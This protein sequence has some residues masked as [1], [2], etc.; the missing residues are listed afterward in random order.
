MNAEKK[1]IDQVLANEEIR[2]LI[3]ALGSGIGEDF[4]VDNLNYHKV[5]I[6]S[7]ADVDGYHIRAIL[8]TFFFRYMKELITEGHVFIGLPP[9]YK[10]EKGNQVEYC[11]DDAAL[12]EAKAKMGK[13]ALVQRYKG[14]GE[15][16][17]DQLW[18]TTMNPKQ[19]SLM[20]VS[21]E[22][23]AEAEKLVSVLMGDAADLRREYIIEHADFNKVDTFN[24]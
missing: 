8:L 18:E 19:R 1:R 11:Y 7:D 12:A 22:D 21:I 20:Q 4:N 10:V 2:T 24:K 5:I 6:L 13:G 3:S 17:A 9:L 15:M 16:S 23:A 14:L